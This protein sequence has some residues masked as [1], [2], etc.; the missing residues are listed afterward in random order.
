M[1]KIRGWPVRAMYMLIAAALVISLII[2]MAPAQRASAQDGIPDAEW[3]RVTTPTTDEWL[4][5]P[6]TD[7]IDFAVADGG[8]TAYAI[9]NNTT[10][11]LLLKS[12]D[13]AATWDDIT[14]AI[15]DEAGDGVSFTLLKVATDG[16]DADFVAVALDIPATT[17]HVFISDDG[18]S[19]FEDTGA[20]AAFTDS[21][22]TFGVYELEVSPEV[23]G[24]RD[25]AIGGTDSSVAELWRSTATG[26]S[27]STWED[28]T[29]L[30]DYPGW[31][32]GNAVVDIHFPTS[33]D[34]DNTI[35]VATATDGAP[36]VV[37]LQCGT[38]GLN[39]GWN[40]NSV[41]G[42]AAVT[43]VGP[44]TVPLVTDVPW[45]TLHGATAGITTP[46]DY[47]GRNSDGRYAW[48]NVNY[49]DSTNVGKI[50]RVKNKSVMQVNQQIEG[51]PWLTNVS[52]VGYIAEGKAIAGVLGDGDGGT[53]ACCEGVQ[54]FRNDGVAQM[55]ICCIFWE[56]ACK[57]P[58]GRDAMAAFYVSADK[59]YAVA[60]GPDV[61]YDESAWSVSFDDGANWNQ[62]SLIDTWINYFSD[63]A[64]SPDC[65]KTFLVSVN[66]YWGDGWMDHGCGCDSVWLYGED[67]PEYGYSE[68]SEHWIRTWCGDLEG[69][70]WVDP[71]S[72]GE[73]GLLRLN[74]E[75]DTGHTVYLVDYGTSTVY[76]SE[77]EGLDCWKRG[78]APVDH[79]VDLAVLDE[80]TIFALGDGGMVAMSDDYAIGWHEEVDSEVA[81]GYTI[82]VWGDHILV[83]STDGEV[84]Y[85][86]DG[87]ETFTELDEEVPNGHDVTVAFDTYFDTNDVIY[88]ATAGGT[89]NGIYQWVI[90]ESTTWMDLKAEPREWQTG[91][92]GLDMDDV[93]PVEVHFTGLVVD[94]P[95]N[96]FTD[97]DNGGVIYASY[98]GSW[99]ATGFTGVARSLEREV[100]V[101]TTCLTWDFLHEGL[102]LEVD[103]EDFEA[104]PDALK[105]CGC[106]T[107]DTNSRLFALDDGWPDYDMVDG[108][109]GALWT[110]EDCYAKKA[111]E[112]TS[113]EDGFVVPADP[114][115]CY[116][117]PFT[118]TWD[119]LCDACYYEIQFALDED[120][121]MLI[122][123]NG[124]KVADLAFQEIEGDVPSFSIMGGSV[125]QLSCEQ[126]YYWRVR[127][128]KAA[129]DQVIHSW[130]SDGYFS[131]APS[132]AAGQI[133]LVSPEPGAME[134]AVTDVGFSWDLMA[135][136]DAFDWWVDDNSDFSSPVES[137]TGL[138]DTAYGCTK[139][140]DYDTTYYW[141]VT[142][143][144]EGAAISSSAVGTFRTMAEPTE[145]PEPEAVETPFWVWVVI[146][147]GAALVIVVIV[148][149]FRTRRV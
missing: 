94:S 79:I 17:V 28:A 3:E 88:A 78:S 89:D 142:A 131:V 106:L 34:E 11:D 40:T 101:C 5:A 140:L 97:A 84:S 36:D 118:L 74:P 102:G 20:L 83:G 133:A 56:E 38:W 35:L 62:L 13:G 75:E 135:E 67:L 112:T 136:A 72:K 55:D 53:T 91:I 145:P 137:K 96:P 114:C 41:F 113:P 10:D 51:L 124:I 70:L 141:M 139:T 128:S 103:K 50:F 92:S 132:T 25:I 109:E 54:V 82:A 143:Y 8:D 66:G 95:S 9:V 21:A 43:V 46:L 76:W 119:P 71:A 68:Y 24:D 4:L 7:I 90:G 42:I 6:Q 148:L 127:A 138:T 123:V 37:Y 93:E 149:I 57:P 98:Y 33:W 147:I 64:K 30:A 31:V 144:N 47:S 87:G 61:D 16:E 44:A 60:L 1:T 125:G 27:A 73:W 12:E 80:E 108:I 59:A 104:T 85:S 81:D 130:W 117:V 19:T 105:I 39:P 14:D 100:T 122:G 15:E 2:T 52:Y 126:T 77:L 120:F 69:E 45:S 115:S 86:D 58:T 111:P 65:N 129:T 99:N 48:V 29:L 134:V 63:I 22:P 121:T 26:D 18:G 49:V 32:A 116:S 23:D 146:G 110:F 107:P